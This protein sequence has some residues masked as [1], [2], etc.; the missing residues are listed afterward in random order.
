MSKYTVPVLADRIALIAGNGQY[1]LD[2]AKKAFELGKQL[3]VI[4]VSGETDPA[5]SRF[6]VDQIF[7]VKVGQFSKLLNILEHSGVKQAVFAGGISRVKL[8]RNFL[9][10]LKAFSLA[11]KLGTVR[12]D[13]LLRAIAEEIEKLGIEVINGALYLDDAIPKSGLL[14]ARD[15]TAEEMA[16]ALIGWKAAKVIGE[17]D[18]GQ[19]VIVYK[20]LV[21]AV[22]AVEGTDEAIS[23]AGLLSN[24]KGSALSHSGAVLVKVCKPQQDKRLDLP[25]FGPRTIIEM[26]RSGLTAAVIEA[27]ASLMIE[28]SKVIK[29]ADENGIA[30]LAASSEL[31]LC[32]NASLVRDFTISCE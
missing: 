19:S 17:H 12:D 6:S 13:V 28:P 10:D 14:S 7:W 22:E 23:R 1:P 21:V 24:L 5:I 26:R 16:D 30:L 32:S 11:A 2:F 27:G 29:M 15:L 31:A 4:A 20:S 9:P 3:V 8:F 25:T 18:I